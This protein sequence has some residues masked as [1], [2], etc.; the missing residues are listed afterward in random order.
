MNKNAF[1]RRTFMQTAGASIA[2][3]ALSPY[4][5]AAPVPKGKIVKPNQ[6]LN[7]A[8]IGCGGKGFTDISGVSTENIVALCDV[9]FSQAEKILKLHPNVPRY[10]D[11][12]KML[13]E[14]DDRIDAVTVS[15]P[16]HMHYAAG[17]EA[18]KRGKH[19]FIQKPLAHSLWQV[20]QLRLA[21][22]KHNVMTQMGNQSHA[23]EGVRLAKEWVQAGILGDV[24][25]VHI[26]T[27]KLVDGKYRSAL[28]NHPKKKTPTPD[29]L[30][31]NLWLGSSPVHRYSPE[32]HPWKW[33]GWWDYGNGALGDIGCH[34]MDAA[35]Y[36]LD[37]AA[38]TSVQAET[39]DFNDATYPDWS[40]VTYK[41]PA[42][43]SMPPV[44]IIWYDGSKLPD[45]PKELEPE[46]E[47]HT[48]CGYLMYGDKA[49]IYEQREKCESPRIIP[50]S[51]MRI[52][53]PKLPP[54]TIPRVPN[55]DPFQEWINSCKGGPKAG[56]NFDYSGPLSEMVLLGNIAIRAKGKKIKWDAKNMQI[57]N[58]PKMNKYINPK[59]H[60][61]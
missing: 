30:D 55:G 1:S 59:Q 22:R 50:E 39:S 27:Q 32:Y 48:Q 49:T 26:W 38:P 19:V 3:T 7:I 58:L 20:R 12:R 60:K 10:K 2:A 5:Y 28:R 16:D 40:I 41:F 18:I 33:R 37:L 52:L 47:F 36:A 44:K 35:F 4:A 46:R 25:E 54:K 14:M 53:A 21:A 11:F 24:R 29:T 61:S 43:G 8:C 45:R 34:T 56:S 6:K 42:R 15:T 31:W 17:I 51:K 13:D 23:S 57:T 9:D